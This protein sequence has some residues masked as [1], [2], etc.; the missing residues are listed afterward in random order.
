MV[1]GSCFALGS[2]EIRKNKLRI[3]I[4]REE[5][6]DC[7]KCRLKVV[8]AM[9][10]SFCFP[11]PK[12]TLLCYTEMHCS[13]PAWDQAEPL[14]VFQCFVLKVTDDALA[15]R[16]AASLPDLSLQLPQTLCPPPPFFYITL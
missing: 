13:S 12:Y 11:L 8:F 4:E 6:G 1:A 14:F 7:R 10:S 2:L 9:A 3:L 15:E 5:E 16:T